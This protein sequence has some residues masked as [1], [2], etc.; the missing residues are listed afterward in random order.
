[1]LAWGIIGT[2]DISERLVADLAALPGATVTAVWGRSAERA[3]DFARTHGIA[4]ATVSRDELFARADVDVVYIATPAH[5]HA[6]IAVEALRAGKHVLIEK[7]IATSAGDAERVYAAAATAGRFAMEAMWMRFN[8]LH[9]EVI[10]RIGD[11]LLGAAGSVRASFGT[12]FQAR[13]RVLTPG[14]GGSILRDRGIYPVTLAHWFLGEPTALSASGVFEDGTDIDG[15]AT[16]EYRLAFAQLAWSGIRFLDLTATVSGER[17]WITIDP[18]FW[19]GSRARLHAGSAE[20]IFGAPEVIDYPRQG[21]GYGPMLA[22]VTDAIARG[23]LEHPW[24]SHADSL[25]ITRTLDAI[26]AGMSAARG[27]AS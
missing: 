14:Q 13:G 8:P 25:A 23:R 20:R 18:M 17:G 5:T 3:A 6:D 26:L 21:N 7:P 19:A 16:L 11:G 15:H 2:G 22:A 9:V 12:P 1:M 10:D 24:H 27:A 4:F